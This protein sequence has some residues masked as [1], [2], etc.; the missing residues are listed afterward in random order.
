[1]ST[2]AVR[3]PPMGTIDP[4]QQNHER[5]IALHHVRKKKRKVRAL[6]QRIAL[7]RYIPQPI[8]LKTGYTDL[9]CME[10][11]QCLYE[12]LEDAEAVT[13]PSL[14]LLVPSLRISEQTAGEPTIVRETFSPENSSGASLQKL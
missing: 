7:Y 4:M 10:F 11:T 6:P 14:V 9:Y 13:D 8:L 5:Q 2:G 3:P 12:A 1:M